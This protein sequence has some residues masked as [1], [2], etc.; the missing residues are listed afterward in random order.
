MQQLIHA[1]CCERVHHLAVAVIGCP[2]ISTVP[3]QITGVKARHSCKAAACFLTLLLLLL[4]FSPGV[5]DLRPA[6]AA[7]AGGG[8]LNPR[9][10]E[11]VATSMEAAFQLHQLVCIPATAA[12]VQHHGEH[13]QQQQ[14]QH[15]HVDRRSQKQQQQQQQYRWP[16][17]ADLAAGIQQRELATLRAIRSCIR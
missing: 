17:L 4:L 8:V 11:G 9:Q 12:D 5:F 10:L 2:R 14:D 1:V 16:C 6:L 15:Q 3:F 7:A 13:H